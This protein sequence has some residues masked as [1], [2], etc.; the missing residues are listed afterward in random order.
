MSEYAGKKVTVRVENHATDWA[1]EAA[2]IARVE[3]K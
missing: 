3:V 2:Y 1:F